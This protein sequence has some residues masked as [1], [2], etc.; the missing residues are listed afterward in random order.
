V[1]LPYTLFQ[2]ILYGVITYSVIGFHWS[3]DKF[4]WYLFV[5]LCTFL[6]YT[7]YGMLAVA[8]SPNA[9][10]AA[11]IAS[12]FYSVFNVFSGFLITRPVSVLN[13]KCM[14]LN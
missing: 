3:V 8:I 7:Y 1:E 12:A 9:Q 5:T 6:Y 11:V 2:T 13:L 14:I 4:F 10:V